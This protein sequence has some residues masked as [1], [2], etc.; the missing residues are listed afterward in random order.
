VENGGHESL[1]DAK[2]QEVI[3]EF[4]RTK[5]VGAVR[6]RSVYVPPPR[7]VPVGEVSKAETT[8]R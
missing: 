4:L 1:L 5:D 8:T 6:G 2:V 3:L 7:F